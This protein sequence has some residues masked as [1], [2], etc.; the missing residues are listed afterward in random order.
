MRTLHFY[1]FLLMEFP[2]RFLARNP[3]IKTIEKN[4][5]DTDSFP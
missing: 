2:F 5:T 1:I 4:A 3:D